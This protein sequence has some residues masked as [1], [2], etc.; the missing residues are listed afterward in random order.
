V[1]PRR[2][3]RIAINAPSI[4]DEDRAAV[5]RVIASGW[6]GS[7][8]ECAAFE[9]DLAE[10]LNAENVVCISS[11]TAGIE[12]LFDRLRI[13]PSS[14]VAVPAW[15]HPATAMPLALR[16]ARIVLVDSDPDTM[17]MSIDS[18]DEVL[19]GGVDLAVPVHFAGIPLPAALGKMCAAAGV[20]VVEDAA[21]AFG[22]TDDD[23]P[24]RGLHAVAAVFSFH[25][26]KNLTCG[27][28]GA[29]ATTDADLAAWLRRQRNHGIDED[30]WSRETTGTW[31]MGDVI[32][33][34]RKANLPDV[35]AA[36]GRS[37]LRRF[38][39]MQAHRHRL[40]DHYRSRLDSIPGVSMVPPAPHI[41]SSDHLVVVRLPPGRR[42][43][44]VEHLDRLGIA[45]GLHF[46]PLHH[47]SWF[48]DHVE[49]PDG[50]L[51]TCDEAAECLL[52][53][54]L[55]NRLVESD[56]DA[57]VDA[58]TS[59]LTNRRTRA[60]S[61]AP[62]RYIDALLDDFRSE[63]VTRFNHL[64]HWDNP[65]AD[66]EP[67]SR[68]D[69]QRRMND[70]LIELA[71]IRD[72]SRVLDVGSGFG[73]TLQ[74]IDGR[75]SG[76]SLT[77]LDVDARQLELCSRMSASATNVL[78]WVQGDGCSL[79]FREASF[80]HMLS[81]EAMWHF[82]SRHAFMSES[83][84]VLRPG[85]RLAVV[86]I[87]VD[88]NAATRRGLTAQ[89]MRARLET[90]FSPWPELGASL[91]DLLASAT[92]VGFRCEQ[93]IDATA[94]TKPTYLDHGDADDRPGAA[95]FS[96]TPGVQ[97]FVEMHL[98]DELRVVYLSLERLPAPNPA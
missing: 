80:D 13:G 91:D 94:H 47:H 64:G 79:P 19:S 22:A 48:R 34:G 61:P 55:H 68:V 29:V 56:V 86:D 42:E 10:Y 90:S 12:L 57:V 23:G 82:P 75:F 6:I 85:G 66:I 63:G 20:P 35:L 16:G 25:P 60:T 1:G 3:S 70:V 44:V 59:A 38:D 46:T 69:A 84:R 37:Q 40:V 97:L 65:C 95:T 51:H 83:A 62:P 67:G 52:T 54:P 92:S 89:E 50:G 98:Q 32:E 14:R 93:V 5:D 24:I 21:H 18:L 45:T 33:P 39:Q 88:P 78:T 72:E 17:C 2:P 96:S 53:L 15:T 71:D 76:M 27:E 28:G 11:C 41:G 81:I 31:S 9:E 26:T 58:V 36:I 4:A 7:G 8:P 87:L 30:A 43:E 74:A 77:G 73:G 49:V